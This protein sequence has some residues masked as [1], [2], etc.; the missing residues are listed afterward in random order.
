MNIQLNKLKHGQNIAERDRA[1]VEDRTLDCFDVGL[2]FRIK[3]AI[4]QD[5]GLE[6]FIDEDDPIV[7]NSLAKLASC[8][9]LDFI[10]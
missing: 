5:N 3:V 9:F 8:N 1:V 10:L 2:Y 4:E 7:R 6:F